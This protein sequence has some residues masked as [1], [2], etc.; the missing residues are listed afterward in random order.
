MATSDI[1]K[2]H[3][4]DFNVNNFP[5]KLKEYGGYKAYVKSLGGVFTKYA[6]YTGKITKASELTEI[7]QYVCGLLS[8]YGVDYATGSSGGGQGNWWKNDLPASQAKDAFYPRESDHGGKKNYLHEKADDVLSD[9]TNYKTCMVVDCETGVDM[10]RFKAGIY[11]G[12]ESYDFRGMVQAGGKIITKMKDLQV[13]DI[14]QYYTGCYFPDKSPSK[15]I[16]TFG[17]IGHKNDNNGK[18]W[19]HVNIVGEVDVKNNTLTTYDTGHAFTNSGEYKITVSRDASCPYKWASDWVAV[20]PINLEQDGLKKG[21]EYNDGKWYYYE[22]GELA[23]GWRKIRWS[24]GTDWFYFDSTGAMVTGWQKLKWSKGENWFFFTADGAMVTGFMCLVWN[25][26]KNWYLFDE[27]G[28]M[29]TG[30]QKVSAT[31]DKSGALTGGKQI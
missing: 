28:A 23:K 17:Y 8:I 16:S 3:C 6:D 20:R 19:F 21:W 12:K 26:V 18:G 15:I 31:F 5:A 30:T 27:N 24:K 9:T 4:F 1:I 22:S 13:G 10:I 11:S 29:Q 2:N 7:G 14:V 25:G